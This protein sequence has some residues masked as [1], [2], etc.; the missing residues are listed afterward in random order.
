M[1]AQLLKILFEILILLKHEL[2][3]F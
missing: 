3:I 1:F 2:C